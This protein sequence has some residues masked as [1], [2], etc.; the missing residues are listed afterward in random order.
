MQHNTYKLIIELLNQELKK[1]DR[2]PTLFYHE[3]IK[4]AKKDFIEHLKEQ[5]KRG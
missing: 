3:E 2:I 5:T 1:A 4:E